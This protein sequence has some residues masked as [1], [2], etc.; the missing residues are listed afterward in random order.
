MDDIDLDN[1]GKKS[2]RPPEDREDYDW[3][4]WQKTSFNNGWRDESLLEFND[5]HP[6][7]EIPNPRRDAGVMK[8]A[9]T[10]DIKKLLRGLNINANKGDGPN[11]KSLYERLRLTTNQKEDV[12]GMKFDG[13]KIIVLDGKGLRFSENV[14]FKSKLDDFQALARESEK[15]HGATAVAMV[16]ETAPDVPVDDNIAKS[17][18]NDSLERVNE[19]ISER[20]DEIMVEL[21]ENEIREFRGILDVRLPTLEQQREGGITVENRLDALK[22]EENNWRD[23]AQRADPKKKLLYESIA[24]VA[25]LKAGELRLRANI[26]PESELWS[27]HCE[28]RSRK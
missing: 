27:K 3:D 16:E 11:A 21:T 1:F 22:I 5:D 26:R 23:L 9:Y 6:G 4:G 20:S 25:A 7:G 10:E 2:D 15:E 19:E 13:V 8:R 28:G 12:N 14:R 17:V 24:D 18:L